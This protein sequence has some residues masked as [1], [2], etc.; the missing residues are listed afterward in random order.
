MTDYY[1]LILK[2]PFF[3]CIILHLRGLQFIVEI[4]GV[5]D[6]SFRSNHFRELATLV[7]NQ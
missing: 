7:E 4:L 6:F 5:F 1:D 3:F 2:L